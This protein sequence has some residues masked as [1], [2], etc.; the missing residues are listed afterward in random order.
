MPTPHV[1]RRAFGA[2]LAL[3]AAALPASL[4]AAA[5]VVTWASSGLGGVPALTGAGGEAPTISGDGRFVAF[6]SS[7]ANFGGESNGLSQIYVR[8]RSTG[9]LQLVS[10]SST[11]ELS[12]SACSHPVISQSGRFLSFISK[13]TNLG[14]PPEGPHGGV[15]FRDLSTQQTELIAPISDDLTGSI[16]GGNELAATSDGRYV[17]FCSYHRTLVA[18]D[19]NAQADVFVKDRSTGTVDRVSLGAAGTQGNGHSGLSAVSISEDGRFVSFTSEASNLVPG[20]TNDQEDVFVRDRQLGTTERV[21]LSVSGAEL[22][23]LSRGGALSADGRYVVFGS[24]GDLTESGFILGGVGVRDRLAGTTE[25]VTV[26]PAGQAVSTSSS[27]TPSISRDGRFVLFDSGSSDLVSGDTNGMLDVFVRDRA[28]DVTERLSVGAG[29]LQGT[30]S[31]RT[32]A[33]PAISDN[34]GVAVFVSDAG[35]LVDDDTNGRTD[36]F[37]HVRQPASTERISVGPDGQQGVTGA[38]SGGAV[39]SADGQSVVYWSDATN[40]VPG[41]TNGVVDYF[42]FNRS[43]GT[44]ERVNLSSAGAQANGGSGFF[45]VTVPAISADGRFVAFLSGA[46]N[47]VPGDTNHVV[48]VFVRDRQAGT[49]ERVNLALDGGQDSWGVYAIGHNLAIS[50]D[51]RYVAFPTGSAHLVADDTNNTVDVFVRD[52]LLGVT[53]RVNVAGDGTPANTD[54]PFPDLAMSGDGRVVAFTSSATNLVPGDTNG[55]PDV[56]VRDR[57][58][59]TTQRVPGAWSLLP[60]L[61]ADGRYVLFSSNVSD[62][63]PGDTNEAWDIFL[64]DRIDDL[65][66]R[67]SLAPGGGQLMSDSR[68]GGTLSADARFVAYTAG[69]ELVPD[70]DQWQLGI[71]RQDRQLDTAEWVSVTEFGGLPNGVS[72]SPALSADGSVLAFASSASNIVSGNDAAGSDVFVRVLGASSL[73]APA[74]L[75]VTPVSATSLRLTWEDQS[76]GETGFAIERFAQGVYSVVGT[77][78]ADAEAFVDTG[79]LP[80]TAYSYRVRAYDGSGFS[81]YSGIA[82]GTTWSLAPSAPTGFAAAAVS[83]TQV[84]LNWVDTADNEQGFTIERASGG[85][86]LVALATVPAN[87]EAYTDATA[88]PNTTYLYVLQAYNTG[89]S[90]AAAETTVTTP[91]GVPAAPSNL[92]AT[93]R[94]LSSIR[95][96]WQD[97]SANETGFRVERQTGEG[98]FV[99]LG[100]VAAGSTEYVDT[101]IQVG[102]SYRYR[103]IAFNTGGDSTPAISGTVTV[104]AGGKLSIAPGRLNFGTVKRGK[105]KRLKL[106]LKNLGK[107]PLFGEIGTLTAPYRIVDGGGAF[108]LAKGKSRK[109]TVEF[110][111]TEV[112][113]INRELSVASTAATGADRLVAVSGR[114]K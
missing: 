92:I 106:T 103:V 13:A 9:S 64:W 99:V 76:S 107:T 3:F 18:N 72:S 33:V 70:S 82:E 78:S 42:V 85:G 66:E 31:S 83:Q 16:A 39:V 51:G 98:E 93:V 91:P 95:L 47:L 4:A 28:L 48:D 55:V 77:A 60:T 43:L 44:I 73:T 27:M 25:A 89:G 59:G 34:G 22:D 108:T 87:T 74:G 10:R 80:A 57:L 54:W 102:A 14:P 100:T 62:L 79:L 20:D 32:G 35:E 52:R 71:L 45:P 7:A 5:G 46:N 41:D 94:S 110:A 97:G 36:V 105:V 96:S 75:A 67:V 26:D 11:G 12:D 2:V 104:Q 40:L 65:V 69:M 114:G 58:A 112:G 88:A 8:D 24:S 37:V 61:N 113:L 53:E 30:A 1:P 101:A 81:P 17:A 15:Y 90:S 109:V 23:N 50:A 68:W 38:A 84:Q 21:S 6:L 19:T 49:T 111:P 56:F 29:G 86:A 63:V